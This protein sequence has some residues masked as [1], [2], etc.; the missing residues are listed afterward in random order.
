MSLLHVTTPEAWAGAQAAGDL[1][2]APFLHLCT[3]AQLPFV[4]SRHFAGR[5]GLMLLWIEPDGLD[6]RWEASEPG[7]DPFPHLYGAAPIAAVT[8]AAPI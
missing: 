4:L 8:G 6:V 7:M 5:T 1:S 2:G 3:I